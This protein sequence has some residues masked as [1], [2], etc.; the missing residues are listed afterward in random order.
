ME[1]PVRTD[2]HV[3]EKAKRGGVLD[4]GVLEH[5]ARAHVGEGTRCA[6]HELRRRRELFARVAAQ[7]RVAKKLDQRRPPAARRGGATVGGRSSS[8]RTEAR[9][10]TLGKSP[11][12]ARELA[13]SAR[14]DASCREQGSGL[15]VQLSCQSSPVRF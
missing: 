10:V 13:K 15:R 5:V 6:R 11:A 1:E 4:D 9:A 8:E 2:T 12:A 7:E 14:A 3:D